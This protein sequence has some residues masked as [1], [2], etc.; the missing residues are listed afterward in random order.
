MTTLGTTKNRLWDYFILA[1]RLL[2]AHVFI[3]YG[4]R[5]LVGG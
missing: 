5:K 2:L 3:S 4:C 1:A